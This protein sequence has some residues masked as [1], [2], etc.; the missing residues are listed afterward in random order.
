MWLR[1]NGSTLISQFVDSFCVIV[2]AHYYAHA[3]DGAIDENAGDVVGT[4]THLIVSGYVFKL[5]AALLDTIPF[6][7]GTSFLNKYL[8]IETPDDLHH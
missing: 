6:Y 7:L 5:V 3:F 2:I 4:L 8:G 1:N